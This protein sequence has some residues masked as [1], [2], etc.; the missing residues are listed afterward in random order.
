MSWREFR[1]HSEAFGK[2]E[3][4]SFSA[5]HYHLTNRPLL[6]NVPIDLYT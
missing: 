3:P 1:L 6:S 5:W 4:V 2:E